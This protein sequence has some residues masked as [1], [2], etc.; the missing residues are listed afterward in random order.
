MMPTVYCEDCGDEISR[1]CHSQ[2]GN[3]KAYAW[4][5]VPEDSED[6][7]RYGTVCGITGRAHRPDDETEGE[8]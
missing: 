1:Y 3:V 6:D 4:T 7:P 2:W 8:S 5:N